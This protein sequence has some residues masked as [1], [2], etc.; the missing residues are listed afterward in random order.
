MTS[1]KPRRASRLRTDINFTCEHCGR[2]VPWGRWKGQ[3]KPRDHCPYCLWSK[4][5]SIGGNMGAI[6][7]G[8]MMKG[9]PVGDDQVVWRCLGCGWMMRGYTDDYAFTHLTDRGKGF[10]VGV[11]MEVF[12]PDLICLS[13]SAGHR[14][15]PWCHDSAVVLPAPL[16]PTSA[17]VTPSPTRKETSCSSSRPPGRA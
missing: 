14:A 1:R 17:A 16:G 15:A 9:T 8:A 13:V 2:A 7:C 10:G 4:H 3:D 6:P 12:P 11:R 5:V